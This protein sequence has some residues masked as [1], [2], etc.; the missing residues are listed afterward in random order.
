MTFT[1]TAQLCTQR[2]RYRT[3]TP[4]TFSV[5]I[6]NCS[7]WPRY[8]TS[9]RENFSVLISN[10]WPS[11][12]EATVVLMAHCLVLP[13]LYQFFF[14]CLCPEACGILV[15]WPDMEPE[16]LAVRALSPNHWIARE[17]SVLPG[18]ELPSYYI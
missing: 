12:S 16:P 8:R 7:Q 13:V 1:L 17:F 10:C 3:S 9:T 2:P 4:E 11:W 6:S 15:S 18:L 5:L 14:F